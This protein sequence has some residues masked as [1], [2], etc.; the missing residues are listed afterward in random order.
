MELVF[1]GAD[2]GVLISSQRLTIE[3]NQQKVVHLV[4]SCYT[5]IS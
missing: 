5:D 3:I 4:G 2:D 1:C